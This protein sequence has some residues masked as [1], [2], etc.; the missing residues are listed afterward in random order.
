MDLTIQ[1][2]ARLVVG[3]SSLALLAIGLAVLAWERVTDRAPV[4]ERDTGPLAVVNYVAILGFAGVGLVSAATLVGASSIPSGAEAIDLSV[5]TLG[6]LI[7]LATALL[8]IWSLRSIGR[9][10]SS[11]AEVRPDTRLVT[12]GAFAVVRHP[13]YLSVLLLWLG[14]AAA[15]LSWVM[16]LC[17]L[18]LIP[19][20]VARS[21]LEEA[22]LIRHFGDAYREYARHVPMLLPIPRGGDAGRRSR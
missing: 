10:M 7:L 12:G 19:P 3:G 11:A 2:V 14:A 13:M 17:W 18:A 15:L 21:R 1:T 4:L 8:A 6:I 20:L 5:R 9:D 22:I 16:A